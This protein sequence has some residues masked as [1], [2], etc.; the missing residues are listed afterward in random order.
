MT[1]EPPVFVREA[2]LR[3]PPTTPLKEA[4]PPV[5]A[6]RL[7]TPS[8][9]ASSVPLKLMAPFPDELRVADWASVAA[10]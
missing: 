1:V 9:A 3:T 2:S 7:W 10:L 4:A 6:V 5:W 8:V